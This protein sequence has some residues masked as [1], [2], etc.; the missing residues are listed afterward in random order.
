MLHDR[1]FMHGEAVLRLVWFGNSCRTVGAAR[2]RRRKRESMP[3]FGAL[4]SF[5]PKLHEMLSGQEHRAFRFEHL[6]R[7]AAYQRGALFELRPMRYRAVACDEKV[8]RAADAST[9]PPVVCRVHLTQKN[10]QR[11]RGHVVCFRHVARRFW[12]L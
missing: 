10:V 12:G 9:I 2:R 7:E 5:V 6:S 11:D 4:V 1:K 3:P 8:A